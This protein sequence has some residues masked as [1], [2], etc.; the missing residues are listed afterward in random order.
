MLRVINKIFGHP[1][2]SDMIEIE[3]NLLSLLLNRI[4]DSMRN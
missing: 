3:L 2:I 1:N 4:V